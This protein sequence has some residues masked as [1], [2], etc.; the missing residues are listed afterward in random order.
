MKTVPDPLT[1]SFANTFADPSAERPVFTLESVMAAVEQLTVPTANEQLIAMSFYSIGRSL[2]ADATAK[3]YEKELRAISER[4]LGPDFTP[5][6]VP[7]L[8]W[9]L[10]YMVRPLPIGLTVQ[11]HHEP[12]GVYWMRASAWEWF[13]AAAKRRF[14]GAA[15]RRLTSE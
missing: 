5:E 13:D 7:S 4:I 12:S 3:L 11:L 10:P 15:H 9:R 1:G 14:R 2:L 8:E 6:L